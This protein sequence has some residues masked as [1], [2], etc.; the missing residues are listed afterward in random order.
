M[1][2]SMLSWTTPAARNDLPP[3]RNDLPPARTCTFGLKEAYTLHTLTK[4]FSG[5][6]LHG[7]PPQLTQR[8]VSANAQFLSC[9]TILSAVD[10]ALSEA[11]SVT[12]VLERLTKVVEKSPRKKREG[13]IHTG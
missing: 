13:Y 12:Y 1:P 8:H 10:N 9:K 7:N 11:L 4:R 5:A 2:P 3:A 6:K